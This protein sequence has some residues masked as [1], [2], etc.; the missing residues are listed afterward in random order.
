MEM[1]CLE[2]TEDMAGNY[3]DV[4]FMLYEHETEQLLDEETLEAAWYVEEPI[5]AGAFV[6]A[7]VY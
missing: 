4:K 7:W 6:D 3:Y 5:V 2:V 1:G